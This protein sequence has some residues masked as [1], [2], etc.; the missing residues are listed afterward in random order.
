[1]PGLNVGLLTAAL[2]EE[3]VGGRGGEASHFL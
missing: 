1:M 2:H 3:A